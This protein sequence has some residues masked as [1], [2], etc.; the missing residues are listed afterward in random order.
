[1]VRVLE[2][3]LR[4]GTEQMMDSKCFKEKLRMSAE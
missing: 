2:K 1:M 4:M 3:K